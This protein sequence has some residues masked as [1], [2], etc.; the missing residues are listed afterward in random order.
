MQFQP[1]DI[2]FYPTTGEF[3]HDVFAKLQRWAGEM[4]D[5]KG[6]GF[7]HV[8]MISTEPDLIIDMKWPRPSFRFVVDDMR[9][10][11]VMRATCPHDFKLRAIYW[12]YFHIN[13][14]YS[15]WEMLWG[16]V[17]AMKA[18][19]FCSGWVDRA[20]KEAGFPLTKM[21]DWIVSPNELASS[22]KLVRVL[23]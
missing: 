14:H 13:D 4:G 1:G 15:F 23:E 3:K 12:A 9:P 7:T 10:K 5:V 20:Y 19:K 8:G 6:P 17:G 2:I 21:T 16:N 22:K 11:L 18:Y